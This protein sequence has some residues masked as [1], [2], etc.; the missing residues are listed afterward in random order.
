MRTLEHMPST[1]SRSCLNSNW[2]RVIST[3]ALAVIGGALVACSMGFGELEGPEN[4]QARAKP[5]NQGQV[6]PT[7]ENLLTGITTLVDNQTEAPG[8]GLYSYVLFE[9]PPTD[10]DK[11]IY[12]AVI[13][14]CLKEYPALGGLV[15]KYRP[16]SLN[17]LHLPVTGDSA[18]SKAEE[19]LQRYNYGRARA[20]L[21]QLSKIK[22]NGGP[23]LVSSISPLSNNNGT[24]PFLYQDLSA[25]RFVSSQDDQTRM[26]STWVLD[27]ISGVSSPRAWDRAALGTFGTKMLDTRHFNAMA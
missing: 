8:Y 11:P 22:R 13:S 16:E 17:A 26:A 19:F 12:L 7:G 3:F 6:K 1:T 14:A 20:L 10:E 18:E 23:Y 24:N 9:S 25:V 5:I 21:N 27:F 15:Q 2:S 4:R